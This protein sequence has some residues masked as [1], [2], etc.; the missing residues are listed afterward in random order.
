MGQSKQRAALIVI[1]AFE[2][3]I[4]SSRGVRIL[5]TPEKILDLAALL[6]KERVYDVR[7]WLTPDDRSPLQTLY[8][9]AFVAGSR[10]AA[11][12]HELS[13]PNAT[14]IKK[15]R[16]SCFFNTDLHRHLQAEGVTC[17]FLTGVNTDYCVFATALD[18]FYLGYTVCIVEDACG[19]ICGVA[20]HQRGLEDI[21]RFLRDYVRIVSTH[22]AKQQLMQSSVVL[23]HNN[24]MHHATQTWAAST[25][26]IRKGRRRRAEI[27]K[28]LPCSV[29][30]M[31]HKKKQPN[32]HGTSRANVFSDI[33]RHSLFS[34]FRVR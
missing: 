6:P 25:P 4:H 31:Q 19:S 5:K 22:E 26:A 34:S 7:L 13:G 8:P 29:T 3:Q 14:F 18:A 16:Y 10:G 27:K 9:V 20:G 30:H 21:E 15:F 28:L 1:D 2:E 32:G 23:Q 12:A 11:L 24:E 33:M 17:V